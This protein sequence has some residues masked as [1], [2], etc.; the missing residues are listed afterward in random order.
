MK[1]QYDQLLNAYRQ[2]S[3]SYDELLA[4][5]VFIE[6]KY[7]ELSIKSNNSL[8]WDFYDRYQSTLADLSKAYAVKP[9]NALSVYSLGL[10]EEIGEVTLEPS[11]EE[12]GDVFSYMSLFCSKRHISFTWIAKQASVPPDYFIPDNVPQLCDILQVKAFVFAGIMKRDFRGDV[13]ASLNLTDCLV[14]IFRILSA[15]VQL[16]HSS[17]QSVLDQNLQK[18]RTRTQSFR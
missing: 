10:V 3:A 18:I 2:L 13:Q 15:L 14:S 11:L 6:R 16:N 9:E 5:Y 12:I 17:V 1:F 4:D 8:Q 7:A